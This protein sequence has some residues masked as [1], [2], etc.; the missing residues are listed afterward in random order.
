M[1]L[2][3]KKESTKSEANNFLQILRSLLILLFILPGA[4]G[5]Q[6]DD[7]PL[8][9]VT[10]FSILA[11]WA[12]IISGPQAE[13]H[14][15]VGADSDAHVYEPTPDDVRRLALADVLIVNGLG[16]DTWAN[17][18]RDASGFRGRL[19]IATAGVQPR[20][21]GD[22]PDPHTWQDL[23]HARTSVLNIATGLAGARP[24]HSAV[25]AARATRYVDT[26][27][28]MDAEFRRAFASIPRED[29]VIITSHDAFGYLGAAYGLT[30]LPAQGLSTHS[31]PT[32]A[33]VGQLIRQMRA[34]RVRAAGC[35][36][37]PWVARV[38]PHPLTWTCT[39]TMCTPC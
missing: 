36:R 7:P 9:V 26:L 34:G 6:I 20:R 30:I 18:L 25:F 39:V 31:E 24:A 12:N 29:R 14:A 22:A 16:F 23:R 3:L 15:L 21:V 11:D 37:M 10:T 4:A 38:R 33:Q 17:R 32:A 35:T 2:I 27:D 5:A 28:Q 8:K 19:I 13:I 1:R